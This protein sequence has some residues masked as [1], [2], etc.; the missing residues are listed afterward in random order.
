LT[1]VPQHLNFFL[2]FVGFYFLPA[3]L[4]SNFIK[5][6]NSKMVVLIVFVILT[7]LF[8]LFPLTYSEEI[9]KAA[10]GTGIIP[11]GIDL[12]SQYLGSAIGAFVK[13]LL[14]AIG[15]LVIIA[16]VVNDDRDSVEVK[17]FAVLAGFIG[18]IMLTPYIAERYYIL[19]VAPLLLILHKFQRDRRIHFL[20]LVFLI[21]MSAA[22]SYWEIQLKSFDNW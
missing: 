19:A 6:R 15:I 18:L 16:K 10:V 12:I 21:L 2:I 3:L 22:F 1:I 11:H 14:W 8:I 17:L 7:P 9:T 4:G 5:L 13:V 20:W